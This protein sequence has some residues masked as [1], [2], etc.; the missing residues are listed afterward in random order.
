MEARRVTWM[1]FVLLG[2]AVYVMTTVL[3]I[4]YVARP[5][6]HAFRL[7]ASKLPW[8]SHYFVRWY[9][10]AKGLKP[11]LVDKDEMPEEIETLTG[12]DPISCHLCAGAWVAVAACLMAGIFNPLEILG[13]YGLSYAVAM[14]EPKF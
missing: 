3:T 2:L 9:E 1:Q 4:S 13:V 7:V 6:R 11:V 5:V 8:C 12:F 10:T 14:Q